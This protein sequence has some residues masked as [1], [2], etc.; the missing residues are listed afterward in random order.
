MNSCQVGTFRLREPERSAFTLRIIQTECRTLCRRVAPER[1]SQSRRVCRIISRKV[2]ALREGGNVLSDRR[3]LCV[4][5]CLFSVDQL[6]AR[7]MLNGECM[8]LS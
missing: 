2:H 4:Y 8:S 7:L 5:E 3:F 6:M 1:N